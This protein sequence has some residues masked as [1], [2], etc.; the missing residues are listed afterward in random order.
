[1]NLFETNN[2]LFPPA[3]SVIK[4]GITQ[5]ALS[6]WKTCRRKFLYW[7]NR[8][9]RIEPEKWA[10]HT[11]MHSMLET[12]YKTKSSEK[13]LKAL[14]VYKL[15]GNPKE[16]EELKGTAEA[17]LQCYMN[18]YKGDL[19][20]FKFEKVE[21]LFSV[22][23]QGYKLLGKKDGV[24]IDGKLRWNMEHKNYSRINDDYLSKHLWFD[25]QNLFYILAER[26]ESGVSVT[27]TLYNILRKPE[28]RKER[29]TN[30][31]YT[32]IVKEIQKDPK[33]YFIRY[34]IPYSIEEIGQFENE[35]VVSLRE[36]SWVINTCTVAPKET[37]SYCYKNESACDGKFQCPFL[38]ACS[39]GTMQ[40]YKQRK[41]LFPELI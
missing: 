9:D 21:G 14:G 17:M 35:L 24:F 13:V 12:F 22:Y 5:S 33:H 18:Y 25:L 32:H 2:L 19:G 8:W 6:T 10:Y 16:T 15:P 28:T 29:S 3:Y 38:D 30:E 1:M 23:F 36:L 34:E 7:V 39:S 37:L 40:G 26:I 4:V 11:M 31:L 41:L 20:R 27:G